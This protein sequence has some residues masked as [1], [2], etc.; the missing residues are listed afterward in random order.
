MK[1]RTVLLGSAAALYAATA[2]HAADA[3]IVEPEPVEFVRVCDAFGAGF[4]FIPGTETCLQIGGYVRYDINI[5][6]DGWEKDSRA[7]LT[8][9]ARSDTEF[10]TLR[11]FIAIQGN[12][13]GEGIDDS[14]AI[15][16]LT[17]DVIVDEAFI[18]LGGLTVGTTYDFFDEYGIGG[19]NDDLGGARVNLIRYSYAAD[20]FN[21][22]VSVIDDN[23]DNTVGSTWADFT[24][25]FEAT[26]GF[27]IGPA[28]V[29][30]IGVYDNDTDEFA[31]KAVGSVAVTPGGTFAIAGVYAS[32]PTYTWDVSEWSVAASYTQAFSETIS[33]SLG[34]QYFDDTN[35]DV[36]DSPDAWTVGANIDWTPVPNFLVRGQVQY[37]DDDV[38]GESVNGRI[39][40]QRSF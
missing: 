14:P 10:G 28:G 5:S 32:G 23:D 15:N 27:D 40:F 4:F 19:E 20:G 30:I 36:I 21:A 8:V 25:N 34:A 38:A 17:N 7:Q 12:V 35:F 33:A 37:E 2:A 39:R 24:P 11:G 1:T 29:Q 13:S 18:Q 9:D 22:G 3:I 6:E 16:E 31:G 26:A